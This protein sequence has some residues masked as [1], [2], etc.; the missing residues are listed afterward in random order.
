[1][2]RLRLNEK[3][4]IAEDLRGKAKGF[5]A[6]RSPSFKSWN[7]QRQDVESCKAPTAIASKSALIN[8]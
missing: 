4:I 8:S 3:S 7:G 6:Q 2:E 1:M 5:M